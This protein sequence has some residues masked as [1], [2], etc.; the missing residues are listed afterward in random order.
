M[1][2][3]QNQQPELNAAADSTAPP[4]PSGA[5]GAPMPAG[6]AEPAAR[7]VDDFQRELDALRDRN[8]RLL[9]DMRN[10]QQRSKRERE[11]ALRYA[12]AEFARELLVVL[13]DLERAMQ[14]ASGADAPLS[15]GMRITHEHFLKLLRTRGIEPIAAVGEPFDPALH[16][17]LLQQPSAQFPA[18]IVA[19]EVARGYRMHERVIRPARVVV[20]SGPPA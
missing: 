15:E 14:A 11:E 19:Q 2:L 3:D 4:E 8:L 5:T 12:E 7:T 20:S 10:L 6:A 17:A 9:A 1:S 13:D 18:G 16:E